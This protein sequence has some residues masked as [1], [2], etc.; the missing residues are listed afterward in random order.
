VTASRRILRDWG[1]RLGRSA[2]GAALAG[3]VAA[4]IDAGWAR[5]GDSGP[6]RFGTFLADAGLLAPVALVIGV[7]AV[8]LSV[9]VDPEKPP[10]PAGFLAALRRRAVGR[11]ADVAAFVPLVVLGALAWTTIS[12]QLSRA[13][14]SV[15][16]PPALSGLALASA[17]L[18]AGLFV[19]LVVLA[20]VP[21][22]RRALATASEHR[23]A[24][25]D[26][27][28]TGGVAVVI[29][30]LIFAFG[31]RRGGVS[32]EG[33]VLGIYGVLKRPE[34][35]LRA[36]A[37]LVGV[38]VT[39]L[40]SPAFRRVPGVVALVL[41]LASLG[42]TARAA[43][44]LA[45][46]PAVAQALERSAP[47]GKPA[48]KALRKATDRDHDGFSGRFGGGDCDDAD[49][50]V[51]PEAREIP[52][53]G[54]DEDC[55]GSDLSS[56]ALAA[57]APAPPAA[58]T[59]PAAKAALP[60]DLN[61]VFITIDT[62]RADLGFLGYGRKVSPNLDALA[63]RSTVYE[64]AYSLASY[65]GKSVGPMLIGKYGSET[66]RNW[67]HF[68]T[69]TKQDTFV[70]ERLQKAGVRTMSVQANRY[71]GRFGG[72]DRG[73]DVVDLSAAPWEIAWEAD[74]DVSSNKLSDAALK[75]VA[76]PENTGKR[77]FLW[78]HYLD[79][80]A[81]YARHKDIEG[82]GNNQRDLYDAEIAFTDKHVGRLLDAIK[83]APWGERTAIIVTSDHGE[84][85]GEHKMWRHGY[86]VWEPLV[87]VPLLVYVPGAKPSRVAVRRSAIDLAP[88]ILE[89][90]GVPGPSKPD[91]N[92]FL[93]G[94]SLLPDLFVGAGGKPAERDV[95]VDMPGGPYNDERRA[96]YHGDLKLIASGAHVEVYDLAKDPGEEQDLADAPERQTIQPYYDAAKARLREI[97]VTGERKQ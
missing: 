29:V 21:P 26:P 5:G 55:S 1:G 75:L 19:S 91:P 8:G 35:D 87:H 25:V 61:V 41:G 72:L 52:D 54:V 94:V 48:L 95:L 68:N 71:F 40:F 17:S 9:L 11:P 39:A 90:M 15:E 53:N 14:L 74:E 16:V 60:A 36:P 65:T 23:P 63:E 81:D 59:P 12:A 38:L 20:L 80:H 32:G 31:V 51:N 86:E 92:D 82:F 6:G 85:F 18:A 43:S 50:N 69:F 49:A 89:L 42:A 3:F 84:A 73:F 67:G 4:W 66:H 22:L 97:K 27:V 45:T 37:L 33:G 56:K 93:S 2:L 83:A 57:L 62:L 46:M 28:V 47:L 76:K 96:L 44:A 7:V 88:T 10:T 13:L 34:L 24:F 79:P 70:A 77:F 58:T 64:R 78:V 30:A